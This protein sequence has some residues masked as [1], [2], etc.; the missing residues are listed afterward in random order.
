MPD[1]TDPSQEAE[2]QYAEME[3]TEWADGR[4]PNT[5]PTGETV[6]ADRRDARAD[7]G[8]DRMP[9]AEEEDAVRG[10]TADPAVTAAYQEATQHG[11]DQ[12]GEGRI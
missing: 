1:D 6:R 2:A 7:H 9:T 5:F 3:D 8:P 12:E 4:L 10:R 11:V